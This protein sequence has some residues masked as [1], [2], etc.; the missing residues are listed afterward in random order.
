[1]SVALPENIDPWRAVRSGL[2]FTGELALA[3]FPRL[4]KVLTAE[5]GKERVEYH[6][7]FE[8]DL[9]GRAMVGGLIRSRLRLPCQR[10]LGE[11]LVDVESPLR[12]ALV[13]D[14]RAVAGMLTDLDPL[15]VIDDSLSLSDLIE[16][17]LLLAIPSVPRHGIGDCQPPAT[18][19][20]IAPRRSI[21]DM[22]SSA[23]A[24]G[25]PEAAGERPN[26]FAVLSALIDDR[27]D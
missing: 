8:R 16:D 6:V 13:R 1:M 5:G 19:E 17:E 20:D 18:S 24:G 21:E 2:S 10:C 15:V 3:A 9:D 26:P 11:V 25:G 12:L 23:E 27:R 4:S 7:S 22:G 14:D